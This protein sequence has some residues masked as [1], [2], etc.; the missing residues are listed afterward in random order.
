MEEYS[1]EEMRRRYGTW[2]R[3][4]LRRLWQKELEAEDSK[5]KENEARQKHEKDRFPHKYER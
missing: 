4:I 3:E 1:D 5:R 2:W